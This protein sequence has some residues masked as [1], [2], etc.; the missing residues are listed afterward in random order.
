M[1]DAVNNVLGNDKVT[2]G[3]SPPQSYSEN[4]DPR[5]SDDMHAARRSVPM[6]CRS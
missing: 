4:R 1:L 3:G 2:A 5:T 6:D